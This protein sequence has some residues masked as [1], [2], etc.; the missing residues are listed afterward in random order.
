MYP[1]KEAKK[2]ALAAWKKIHVNEGLMEKI[3]AGLQK[4]VKSD[5]W[6]REGGRFIPLPATWL[7]GRRW[8]D[9]V[10]ENP[11]RVMDR[12]KLYGQDFPQRDYSDVDKEIM[13]DLAV[14]MKKFLEGGGA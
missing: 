9:E 14:K 13:D 11:D 6:T 4:Q 8:E 3:M 5:Q 12:K 1:R 10:K 7:N 2:N